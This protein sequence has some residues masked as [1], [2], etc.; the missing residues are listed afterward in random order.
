MSGELR[1]SG[2][3]L[4]LDW[5]LEKLGSTALELASESEM[6]ASALQIALVHLLFNIHGILLFYPIPGMRWPLGWLVEMISSLSVL[7]PYFGC[8]VLAETLISYVL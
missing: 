3:G 1:D 6:L 4:S 8:F 7:G 2:T 5:I